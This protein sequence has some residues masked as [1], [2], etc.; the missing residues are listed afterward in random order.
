M[1]TDA[2]KKPWIEESNG[3]AVRM[4][5]SKQQWEDK[6]KPFLEFVAKQSVLKSSELA[7]NEDG[8]IVAKL[9]GEQ[10]PITRFERVGKAAAE[11]RASE[12]KGQTGGNKKV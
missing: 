3:I 2:T 1:M 11:K 12:I 6:I 7:R 9:T 8:V 10:C 4:K 5:S